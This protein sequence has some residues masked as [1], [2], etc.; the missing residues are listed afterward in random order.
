M[1]LVLHPSGFSSCCHIAAW[2][3]PV[4]AAQYQFNGLV[5]DGRRPRGVKIATEGKS[6][7]EYKS[8]MNISTG[9]TVFPPYAAGFS[10]V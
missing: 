3:A 2:A 10:S 8:S 1:T 7:P 5:V 4:V 6:L 9:A